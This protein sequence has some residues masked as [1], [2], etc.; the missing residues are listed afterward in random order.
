MTKSR[1]L[2][3]VN[4]R[5][6]LVA[7]LYI[8]FISYL[9]LSCTIDNT[10]KKYKVAIINYINYPI[11]NDSIKGI[12]QGLANLG[13]EQ[14]K[15]LDIY[16]FN[17]S[18]ESDK[19]NLIAGEVIS[20]DA[21]VVI[22]VSTPVSQV[23]I[24]A[25]PKSKQIVFSTVTNPDDVEIKR[26]LPNVTGV[27]DVVNYEANIQLIRDLFPNKRKIGLIYNP[28]EKNSVYG[29]DIV[30][31]ICK[32][33][34]LELRT[35]AIASSNEIFGAASSLENT[36]DLFYVGS[37]NT[38]VS[39][40]GSLLKVAYEKGKPVLSSDS[41]SVSNG[42]LAAISVDYIDLGV[43]VAGLV[44]EVLKGKKAG[45][46]PNVLFKGNDLIINISAAKI[47]KFN[48]PDIYKKNAKNII[49]K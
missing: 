1:C 39:G 40:I 32:R 48:F 13:Y 14:G 3:Y 12:K 4:F 8:F 28:G 19:L 21:D 42:T 47:L 33:E 20:I 25:M 16:E 27:S 31:A 30:K 41:G 35:V 49:N 7:I 38:V 9:Q 17:A 34:G 10:G 36:V 11:L 2:I 26:K 18:G 6:M 37:D 24:S 44:D 23:I 29:V 43:R 15:N 45:E 22:P 46:I 5:P